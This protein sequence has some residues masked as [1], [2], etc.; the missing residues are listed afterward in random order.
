[1]FLVLLFQLVVGMVAVVALVIM[2]VVVALVV[3][4]QEQ[5]M[6]VVQQGEVLELLDKEIL[7]AAVL[8]MEAEAEAVLAQVVVQTQV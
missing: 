3:V 1:M 6:V 5:E 8:I 4:D 7:A 2:V